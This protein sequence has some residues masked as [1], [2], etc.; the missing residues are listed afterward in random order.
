MRRT[1]GK[2]I[3]GKHS[4]ASSQY[5]YCEKKVVVALRKLDRED[6]VACAPMVQ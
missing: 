5:Q 4:S 6:L 3:C 1:L 2:L